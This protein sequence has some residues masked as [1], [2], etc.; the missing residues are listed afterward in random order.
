MFE[1]AHGASSIHPARSAR[2]SLKV[3]RSPSSYGDGT[4]RRTA[5]PAPSSPSAFP[6][7]GLGPRTQAGEPL[8]SPGAAQEGRLEQL[9]FLCI[10]ATSREPIVLLSMSVRAVTIPVSDQARASLAPPNKKSSHTRRDAHAF[11]SHIAIH[12]IALSAAGGVPSCVSCGRLLPP[13]TTT[14]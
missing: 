7:Q 10:R 11:H 3:G 2:T 9:G 13:N 4:Q 6:T 5:V 8:Q 12:N 14:R 1:A